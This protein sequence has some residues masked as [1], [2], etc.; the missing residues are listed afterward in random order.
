[1]YY[2][3]QNEIMQLRNKTQ[4]IILRTNLTMTTSQPNVISD[5]MMM[6]GSIMYDT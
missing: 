2:R 3:N 4:E 1:M 5:L 6:A